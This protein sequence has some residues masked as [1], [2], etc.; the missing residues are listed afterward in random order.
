MSDKNKKTLI[1]PIEIK[2][3][4]LNSKILLSLFCA[5]LGMRTYIGNK[6]SIYQLL[7]KIQSGIYFYKSGTYTHEI[8]DLKK[9]LSHFVVLDEEIGPAVIYFD[10]YMK[11]RVF[12]ESLPMIDLFYAFGSKDFEAQKRAYGTDIKNIITGWP[13][14][15]LWRPE[16]SG[17]YAEKVADI[18]AKYGNY[19]FFPSNFTI[20][21]EA[22]KKQSY[23]DV[24]ERDLNEETRDFLLKSI[25]RS[26]LAYQDYVKLIK[27]VALARP[28]MNFLVRPH[29]SDDHSQWRKNLS[30]LPNVKVVYEGDITPWLYGAQAVIHYGC[31]TAIQAGMN[32]IPI[33]SYKPAEG[34]FGEALPYT[35]SHK[36]YTEI[37][38]LDF[39]DSLG[40]KIKEDIKGNVNDIL[41][42]EIDSL[43][44]EFA[45]SKIATTLSNIGTPKVP[46]INFSSGEN[47]YLYSRQFV[48][49]TKLKL[50]E[51]F[52]KPKIKRP[53]KVKNGITREEV[54]SFIEKLAPIVGIPL[55]SIHCVQ[56]TKDLIEIEIRN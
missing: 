51:I 49:K 21:T 39:L 23:R 46:P 42:D 15:D 25:E 17:I 53:P 4:E 8:I 10:L 26:S 47:V 20:N 41:K 43:E 48:S 27:S 11:L 13:R 3:R 33:M 30:N 16:F 32:G 40:Q 38:V 34:K 36:A 29:P 37:E 14:I 44:G 6:N 31:T 5:K 9:T 55:S 24:A 35:I 18:K 52:F 22:S 54:Y 45:S 19:I 56:K 1:L 28:K 12:P 7:K 50:K 2:V